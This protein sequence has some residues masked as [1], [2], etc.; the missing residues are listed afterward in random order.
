MMLKKL[1]KE[2]RGG[3]KMYT[4]KSE[5]IDT[6]LKWGFRDSA[7]PKD[8]EK[9]DELINKKA[10]EGWELVEYS[11]MSNAFGFRSA[12]LVTFKKKKEKSK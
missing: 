7:S 8:V 9:L 6:E 5:V 10:E 11:Y 4:Y 3:D 12:I 1:K 2:S